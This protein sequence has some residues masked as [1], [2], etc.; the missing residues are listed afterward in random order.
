MGL[1]VGVGVVGRP[2]SVEFRTACCMIE[3][4]MLEC[5]SAGGVLVGGPP[6]RME[7]CTGVEVASPMA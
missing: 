7:R 5:D 4:P 3:N 2:V 1:I 6:S